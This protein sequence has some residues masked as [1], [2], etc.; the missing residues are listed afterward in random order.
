MFDGV[1]K[2]TTYISATQLTA[3]ISAADVVLQ[4][5]ASVRVR[6]VGETGVG[7]SSRTFTIAN[8]VPVIM[9][10]S[11]ATAR[12]NV[13]VTISVN[14]NGFTS[15]FYGSV[16]LLRPPGAGDYLIGAPIN[17]SATRLQ[18]Q[19]IPRSQG[20]Y[21][22]AIDNAEINGIGGGTSADATLTVN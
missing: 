22:F 9:N 13:P 11:P 17:V 20:E 7:S 16:F 18:F 1:V 6:P 15:G 4:R 10:T 12:R 21:T 2:T 3:S 14:G 19:F 8:P 5:S